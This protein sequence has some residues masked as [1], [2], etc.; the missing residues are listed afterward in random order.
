MARQMDIIRP[1]L[2]VTHVIL[3][4]QF[5]LTASHRHHHRPTVIHSHTRATDSDT[6]PQRDINRHIVSS[7]I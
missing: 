2:I 1:T 6:D 4:T 7:P 5:V 3:L